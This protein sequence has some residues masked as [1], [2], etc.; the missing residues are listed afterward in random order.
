MRIKRFFRYFF[1]V[2]LSVVLLFNHAACSHGF[3]ENTLIKLGDRNGF[4]LIDQMTC[5]VD[6]GVKLV[7]ASYDAGYAQWVKKQVEAAGY[8][9]TNCYC[10][11]SFKGCM[12]ENILCTPTQ[13]FYLIPDNRCTLSFIFSVS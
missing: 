5:F 3:G 2:V 10:S 12:S 1:K 11:L 7:V 8:C 9:V 6:K 4:Y 13:L